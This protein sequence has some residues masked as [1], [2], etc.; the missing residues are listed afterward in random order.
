MKTHLVSQPKAGVQLKISEKI[1]VED[2]SGDGI[3]L[4][5]ALPQDEM[6]YRYRNIARHQRRKKH[7]LINVHINQNDAFFLIS[8]RNS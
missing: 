5:L 8:K 7:G 6:Y 3:I 2:F 4:D 1:F